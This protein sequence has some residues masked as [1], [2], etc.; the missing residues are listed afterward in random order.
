MILQG[1][2][3]TDVVHK[4]MGRKTEIAKIVLNLSNN[5][6]LYFG[7]QKIR[8]KNNRQNGKLDRIA[9]KQQNGG[10][11]CVSLTNHTRMAFRKNILN[12]L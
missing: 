3:S 5:L 7:K 10:T 11:H 1:S 2:F 4:E 6:F 9:Q 12:D 8:L